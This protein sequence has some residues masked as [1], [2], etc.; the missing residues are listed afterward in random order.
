MKNYYYLCIEFNKKGVITM[1]LILE[2]SEPF[3]R[4]YNIMVDTDGLAVVREEVKDKTSYGWMDTVGQAIVIKNSNSGDIFY[5]KD[6]RKETTMKSNGV[7]VV[8]VSLD[9]ATRKC[10][11]E[12]GLTIQKIQNA[13]N[14]AKKRHA[15]FTDVVELNK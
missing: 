2:I 10:N 12:L 13:I 3:Y 6:F 15:E 4:T 11:E 14:N 7:E 5:K 8:K 1:K 9:E